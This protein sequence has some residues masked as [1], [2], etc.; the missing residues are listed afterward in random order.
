MKKNN[1]AGDLLK[2]LKVI[3]SIAVVVMLL[4]PIFL[5]LLLYT[6]IPTANDLGN[7]EW[8]GFWG[9]YIGGCFGGLCTLITIYLTIRYYEKQENEHK[10]ELAVQMEKHDE[11]MKNELLRKYRPLII[12]RPNGGSGIEG[13]YNPFSL[14]V[15]NLSEYA[16]INLIIDGVYEPKID[17]GS[18]IVMSIKSAKPGGGYND[19]LS[20]RVDD[21]VGHEYIWKYQLEKI[22]DISKNDGRML[23]RYYYKIVEE[24][25][26]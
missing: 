7:K 20:V 15:S 2:I 19:F 14:H 12:L 8:L 25:I 24:T 23:D 10:T 22:E 11:E 16:A 26:K 21:V 17:K 6:S 9:S 3:I 18:E 1:E 5:N 4:L 13:K